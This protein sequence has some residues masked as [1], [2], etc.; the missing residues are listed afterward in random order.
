[1]RCPRAFGG[2]DPKKSHV[3]TALVFISL[4]AAFENAQ[5]IFAVEKAAFAASIFQIFGVEN[6]AIF[7]AKCD[8]RARSALRIPKNRI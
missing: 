5:N 4:S 7:D 2:A 6:A 1:M 3:K 8:A